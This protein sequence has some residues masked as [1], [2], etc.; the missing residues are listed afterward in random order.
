ME[1]T[2]TKHLKLF[3]ESLD[4]EDTLEMSLSE[5]PYIKIVSALHKDLKDSGLVLEGTYEM[6]NHPDIKGKL[7]ITHNGQ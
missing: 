2:I 4:L 7:K 5:K 1:N 6:W 3:M